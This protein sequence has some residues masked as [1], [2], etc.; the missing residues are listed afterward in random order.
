MLKYYEIVWYLK[1]SFIQIYWGMDSESQYNN[2][3]QIVKTE[4]EIDSLEKQF[5]LPNK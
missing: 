1:H 5:I 3:S 4:P 2:K